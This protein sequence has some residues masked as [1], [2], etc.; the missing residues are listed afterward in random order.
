[1]SEQVGRPGPAISPLR[2][3][4]LED[5]T[6]LLYKSSRPVQT[7]TRW[8]ASSEGLAGTK[9]SRY[10]APDEDV[11]DWVLAPRPDD[12]PGI[13]EELEAPVDLL[14]RQTQSP[15]DI[16]MLT[17]AIRDLHLAYPGKFR[18]DV[19]IR[20][21][22]QELFE[23]NP[24]ITALERNAPTTNTLQA[25]YPLHNHS[26]QLPFHF[27]HGFRQDLEQ[28][29][30]LPIDPTC[31]YGDLHLTAEEEENPLPL[32]DNPFWIVNAGCKYDYTNKLWE[33]ARFQQIV[34]HFKDITFVQIGSSNKYHFHKPL[35]GKNVINLIGRTT[36]R[37]CMSLM[38]HA[39]GVITPV[40]FPMHLSAAIE[41]HPKFV[42]RVMTNNQRIWR[43]CIV[44]AGG[45]EPPHW[46]AYPTHA[47]LHTVGELPC[48]LH[49]GCWKSRIERR[50]DG[51]GKD[52][53]LCFR[54]HT[55]SSGQVI[56]ECLN[57][58]SADLVMEHMIRYMKAF[59]L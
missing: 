24:Y 23:N 56:P 27:I 52:T 39:F 22:C 53:S 19:M 36:L 45:R 4:L 59:G 37:Q 28:K 32:K 57:L 55:T 1:M 33:F 16:I 2:Q 44:I 25:H 54:P 5:F 12:V 58:I 9:Q 26:N 48:C 41:M 31:F 15:G 51:D 20:K 35:E 17:A 7:P 46:E 6:K 50:N 40:S 47:F 42:K 18:T 49:G 38:Y 8:K 3:Q 43:P 10:I 14:I 11:G 34:D 29:L 30:G 13:L 21:P